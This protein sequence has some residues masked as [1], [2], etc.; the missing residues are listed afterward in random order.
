MALILVTAFIAVTALAFPK[1]SDPLLPRDSLPSP[2][3][4]RA[5]TP[6]ENLEFKVYV[7][8]DC[9]GDPAGIYHGNYGY[10]HELQQ[11]QSYHLNRTLEDAEKLAFFSGPETVLDNGLL[12]TQSCRVQTAPAGLDAATSDFHLDSKD[13]HGRH[14]G[15][16]TLTQLRF[17]PK[18]W[19]KKPDE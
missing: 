8:K 14:E 10:Y 18:I 4:D 9:I 12:H 13:N 3:G 2:K 6:F 7:N 11:M 15:C 17:C 5:G 1:P 19:I 16:H